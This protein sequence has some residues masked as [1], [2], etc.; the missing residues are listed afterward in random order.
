MLT[1]MEEMEFSGASL[2]PGG[3]QG[4]VEPA[5]A[6]VSTMCH[7]GAWLV[8]AHNS[9]A[10]DTG[11]LRRPLTLSKSLISAEMGLFG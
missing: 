8:L 3:D 5:A 6:G 11:L 10:G 2:A 7:Q 1:A 9:L 4:T